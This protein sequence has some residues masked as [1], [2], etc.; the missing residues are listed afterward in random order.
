MIEKVVDC[1]EIW[2]IYVDLPRNP[3]KN[4]N[5]YVIKT[6]EANMIID[7]GFNRQECHDALWSGIRELQLDMDKTVLFLTH[8][9]SDHTGL[10]EDFVNCGCP[11]YMGETDYK[12]NR[13]F[14]TDEFRDSI[15]NYYVSEGMPEEVMARQTTHNQGAKYM[16]TVDFEATQVNDGDIIK[17]G[18]LEIQ[19]VA[20][21]GH[22]PGHMMLYIPEA[23]ILFTGDHVLFDITPN[24]TVW[25]EAIHS[26]GDYM[27][28]L[29]KTKELPV[30]IALPAHRGKH[31]SLNERIDEIL[32][33]H[34]ERLNE[35]IEALKNFPDSD[36]YVI[37][38][39]VTW[40]MKGLDWDSAPDGQ[41]WFAMGETI[42]HLDYLMTQGKAVQRKVDGISRYSLA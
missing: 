35:V 37:A 42:A 16:A 7:T 26:L 20:T 5:S 6:K 27:D 28:S 32:E 19:C 1:P 38:S 29:R 36:A 10:V 9:H 21:P 31:I 22:T 3:L 40:S 2:K 14:L 30:K 18:S 25:N 4:L 23:E 12:M 11:I 17:L 13:Q 33:H 39:K 15:H 8:L 41:K 34:E 24:I